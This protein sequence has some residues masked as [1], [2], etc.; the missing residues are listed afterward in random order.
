M[1]S[2]IFFSDADGPVIRIALFPEDLPTGSVARLEAAAIWRS[3]PAPRRWGWR[4]PIRRLRHHFGPLGLGLHLKGH[5]QPWTGNSGPHGEQ[6]T[7]YNPERRVVRVLGKEYPLPADGRTLVLLIDESQSR[8]RRPGIVSRL[9]DIPL[10]VRNS[11]PNLEE[12]S[13]WIRLL[14]RD[15]EVRAFMAGAAFS[16]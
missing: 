5:F 4:N 6:A 2:V 10:R 8:F 12:S 13:E 15:L 16:P 1:S 11:D 9:L 3:S 7:L 14:Q